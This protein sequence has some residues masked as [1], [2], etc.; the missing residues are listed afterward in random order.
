MVKTQQLLDRHRQDKLARNKK[1]RKARKKADRHYPKPKPS[2]ATMQWELQRHHE[3]MERLR[4]SILVCDGEVTH[5]ENAVTLDAES[6]DAGVLNHLAALL[7]RLH[8]MRQEFTARNERQMQI[9]AV[10][11]PQ[12]LMRHLQA[13]LAHIQPEISQQPVTE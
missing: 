13:M 6:S 9:L 7:K 3:A 11:N 12:A 5:I 10:Y 4:D 1:R 8:Q 2:R